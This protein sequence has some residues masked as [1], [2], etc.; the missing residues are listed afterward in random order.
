MPMVSMTIFEPADTLKVRAPV[1]PLLM[2]P[3]RY[4]STPASVPMVA[5]L[6]PAIETLP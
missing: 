3:R 2:P 4:R 1:F 5:S 6:E